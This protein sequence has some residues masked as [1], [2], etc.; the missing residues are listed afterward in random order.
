MVQ[1]TVP[2]GLAPVPPELFQMARVFVREPGLVPEPVAA[3]EQ[4]EFDQL[5]ELPDPSGSIPLVQC[6]F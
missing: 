1:V 6:R 5:P 4:D 3:P 2:A